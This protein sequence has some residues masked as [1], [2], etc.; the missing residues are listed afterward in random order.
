VKKGAY[1][2]KPKAKARNRW[3]EK[4][5]LPQE[6]WDDLDKEFPSGAFFEGDRVSDYKWTELTDEQQFDPAF[7]AI[8][9]ADY[10]LPPWKRGKGSDPYGKIAALAEFVRTTPLSAWGRE[11][12]ADFIYRKLV[13]KRRPLY[14]PLS[15]A[16]MILARAKASVR[17]LQA[18]GVSK[19]KALSRIARRESIPLGTLENA[20]NEKRAST[21]LARKGFRGAVSKRPSRRTAAPQ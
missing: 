11:L 9:R 8:V 16:D 4:G 20:V 1:A 17:E 18:K 3:W 21:R 10:N 7:D 19:D 14:E 6:A 2:G 15:K 13:R 5:D 12:L